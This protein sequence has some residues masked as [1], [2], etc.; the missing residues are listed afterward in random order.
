M[1][2]QFAD[3][4]GIKIC[5][6][7]HGDGFPI[8]L[9]HGIGAKKE[10]WIAQLKALSKKYRVIAIDVRGTG[11]SDRPNVLYTM[12]MLAD[13]IKSLMDYLKIEKAHIVG[14]SMGGMIAQELVLKYPKLV[15]KLILIT[16]SPGFPDEEGVEMMIKG[17]IEEIK[18]I[19]TNPEQSFWRKARMLFH[20]KFRKEMEANPKK[21]FYGIWSAEDLIKEDSIDPPTAQDLINQGHAIKKHNT[22]ER[23]I[24][25]KND[26][27]LLASSH[28]RLTSKSGMEE[29]SKKIPKSTLKVIDRAGHYNH[30][31]NA[32]EFNQIILDFLES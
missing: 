23:L 3:A 13:D 10:T 17:R 6:S 4:N 25:I 31:S 19:R 14:R 29:M 32:P 18:D 28:D 12:E 8:I 24:E 7:D 5:Y 9:I 1:T 22:S 16:T 20:Q 21:K 27:L 15:E 2:E 11:K 26:T 30:L